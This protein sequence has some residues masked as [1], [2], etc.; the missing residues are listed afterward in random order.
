[1][2][3]FF[4]VSF[5]VFIYVYVFPFCG[6]QLVLKLGLRRTVMA[7]PCRAM[8][9]NSKHDQLIVLCCASM[10]QLRRGLS[11]VHGTHRPH[12]AVPAFSEL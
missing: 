6:L 8:Y 2:F 3:S 5:S 7:W 12:H 4:S 10:N 11:T 1:M 9:V